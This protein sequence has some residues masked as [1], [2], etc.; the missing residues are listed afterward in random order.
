MALVK[1]YVLSGAVGDVTAASQVFS[2]A[3][4]NP[5]G[6]YVSVSDN[7]Y[8]QIQRVGGSGPFKILL[9]GRSTPDNRPPYP[10]AQGAELTEEG[11]HQVQVIFNAQHRF[12]LT[13]T[14]P[15][16]SYNIAIQS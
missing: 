12:L 9:Q 7:V 6:S 11:W 10:W 14:T 15:G 13:E 4:I 5:R 1:D 3:E 8:V 2:G 16:Q